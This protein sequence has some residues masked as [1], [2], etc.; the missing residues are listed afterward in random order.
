[1]FTA[2]GRGPVPKIPT[3]VTHRAAPR[4]WV[5]DES[6]MAL[7][8]VL[9]P[10]EYHRAHVQ[11]GVR[12]DG[13]ALLAARK[14]SVRNAAL[15]STDGSVLVRMGHTAVLAGVQCD[16]TV[17]SEAEPSH[18]R[19]VVGVDLPAVCSP[20]I[21]AAHGGSGGGGGSI[22]RLDRDKA[23]LVELLQR[24][25]NG[26]LVSLESLCIAEGVATWSCYCELCVLEHDGNLL[27]A[28]MLAMMAALAR[29]RLPHV[30]SDEATGAL[31]VQAEAAIPVRV[32]QPL[33]PC[34]FSVLADALVLD[35]CAE[36]EA[37]SS[38]AFTLLLDGMGELRA[39][40]KPGGAPLPD[41][42]L[43]A[44]VAAA[45]QRLPQLVD[46]L[47]SQVVP[48]GEQRQEA[49]EATQE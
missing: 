46:A 12:P 24:T 9:D 49:A 38:T 10:L 25:A 14:L 31:S 3:L 1:M 39:V 4:A 15:S 43:T 17:P 48:G 44:C 22:S 33:Y 13:R 42:S 34:S 21:A 47:A 37:L 45:R 16:P 18:G 5:R 2:R 8:R 29:V 28:A 19:V 20:T 41:G 32:V 40:H 11:R 7:L 36:E 30:T 27:D 35:P 6:D 23:V 26:G